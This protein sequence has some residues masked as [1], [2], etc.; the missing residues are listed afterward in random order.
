VDQELTVEQFLGAYCPH[1]TLSEILKEAAEDL[2]G[3][4]VHKP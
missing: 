3:V 2:L 4:S 1:P